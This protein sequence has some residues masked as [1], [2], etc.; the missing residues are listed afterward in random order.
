MPRHW[1]SFRPVVYVNMLGRGMFLVRRKRNQRMSWDRKNLRT[2]PVDFLSS[3]FLLIVVILGDNCPIDGRRTLVA[4]TWRRAVSGRRQPPAA[5]WRWR[6]AARSAARRGAAKEK[7][8]LIGG[9]RIQR[10]TDGEGEIGRRRAD[11][12]EART[13]FDTQAHVVLTAVFVLKYYIP[14]EQ[15]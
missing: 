4:V 10:A 9:K 1:A 7:N 11:D 3:I 14:R 8:T 13:L 15:L 6:N 2:N 12:E 5:T